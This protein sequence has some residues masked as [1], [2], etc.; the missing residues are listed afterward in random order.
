MRRSKLGGHWAGT[1]TEL[2][3]YESSES[4]RDQHPGAVRL[5]NDRT[6]KEDIHSLAGPVKKYRMDKE[7]NLHEMVED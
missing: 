5:P 1:G 4:Y 7:G 2:A 3:F 6:A